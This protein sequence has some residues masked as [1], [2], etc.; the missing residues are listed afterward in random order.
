MKN[1]VDKNTFIRV[2]EAFAGIGAQHKAITNIKKKFKVVG[3]S[4][5]DARA[6]IAYS[7]VHYKAKFERKLQKIDK[8]EEERINNYLNIRTFSLDSKKPSNIRR[9]NLKFKKNLIAANEVSKN[10]P[11]IY[12]LKGQDIIDKKV[13]LLTYSFPC[14]GLSI[15]NMGRAKGIKRSSNSTS[16]LIWQIKRILDEIK[17]KKNLPK[18]LLMENVQSLVRKKHIKSYNN[19]KNALSKIG[20]KTFTFVLNGTHFG[21][22]Q[23]RKRVFGLSI[24]KNAQIMNCD[25][26]K[27]EDYL[28]KNYATS[29]NTKERKSKYKKILSCSKEDEI[30]SAIPNNTPSRIMM[31]KENVDLLENAEE[32]NWMF[33]T[34]TTKQDRHPNTGMIKVIKKKNKLNKRFLTTREAYLLMGFKEKDFDNVKTK[35]KEKIITK[36]SLYR[37]AGNSIIVNVLENVFK[38]INE[39]EREGEKCKLWEMK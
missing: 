36:E 25:D 38:L 9:K 35:W 13:D 16:N 37:Q 3:I 24:R 17:N 11:N 39:I 19:W 18:Y 20:Y 30:L 4:E 28:L 27:M 15:A 6:I 22:V 29:L 14:Q 12:D 5:W 26:K 23:K 31:A 21:S 8:W 10:I 7:L 1:K 2:F 33:N 32:K 34:L